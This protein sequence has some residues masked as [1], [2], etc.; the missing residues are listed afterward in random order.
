MSK[1]GN[2][3]DNDKPHHSY[4]ITDTQEN[5]VFKYVISDDPVEEDGLSARLRRQIN[6]MNLIVGWI[7]FVDKVLVFNI[8]GRKEARDLEDDYIEII[9]TNKMDVTQEEM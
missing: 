5:D 7:R 6:F 2:S 9:T 3:L 1:H 8:N 4:E